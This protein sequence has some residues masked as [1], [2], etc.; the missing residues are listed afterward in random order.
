[1]SPGDLNEVSGPSYFQFCLSSSSVQVFSLESRNNNK[2]SISQTY[3][4]KKKCDLTTG[5]RIFIVPITQHLLLLSDAVQS[6]FN[7]SW[8]AWGWLFPISLSPPPTPWSAPSHKLPLLSKLPG[9]D[10]TPELRA[11]PE[12][13]IIATWN[14]L[15][16]DEAVCPINF[17]SAL[18]QILCKKDPSAASHSAKTL[19]AQIL[20]QCESPWSMSLISPALVEKVTERGEISL[21][22]LLWLCH[23]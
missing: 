4:I 13:Y 23:N 12:L 19:K 14:W 7:T 3:R 6:E 11:F 16:P 18:W 5:E 1:M 2:T 9:A 15:L 8:K 10:G 22:A 21:I 17:L 20:L